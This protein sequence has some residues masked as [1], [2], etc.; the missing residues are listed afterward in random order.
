LR[1]IVLLRWSAGAVG[2]GS[3]PGGAAGGALFGA[4]RLSEGRVPSRDYAGRSKVPVA[5]ERGVGVRRRLVGRRREGRRRA[6]RQRAWRR[7][8]W[9][10]IFFES[11]DHAF[12]TM[13]YVPSMVRFSAP[14][15][16][17]SN[18]RAA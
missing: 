10:F 9:L 3:A 1:K 17:W 7:R 18:L 14:P 11:L 2:A 8:A 13:G 5:G 4:L 16:T 12:R 15:N 6:G